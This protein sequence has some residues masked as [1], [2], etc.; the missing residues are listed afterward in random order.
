MRRTRKVRHEALNL[1]EVQAQKLH[2][3]EQQ[4]QQLNKQSGKAKRSTIKRHLRQPGK[5]GGTGHVETPSRQ[6]PH[7]H[8]CERKKKKS[9]ERN[10]IKTTLDTPPQSAFRT[11]TQTWNW[12]HVN[13]QTLKVCPPAVFFTRPRH[14]PEGARLTTQAKQIDSAAGPLCSRRHSLLVPPAR[15]ANNTPSFLSFRAKAGQH[16]TIQQAGP[17]LNGSNGRDS[18]FSISLEIHVR[19]NALSCS[20]D[21]HWP[22][23]LDLCAH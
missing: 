16:V 6:R 20:N 7:E 8:H 22:R 13:Q 19:L 4:I 23:E 17:F 12:I 5:T 14:C 9:L 3:L 2:E 18:A 1:V 21:L 11:T 15:H 10:N